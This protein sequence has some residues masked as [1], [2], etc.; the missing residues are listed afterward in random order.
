MVLD[1]NREDN[2]VSAKVKGSFQDSYEIKLTLA[3]DKISAEC[4]CPLEEEWCKH[5]VAVGLHSIEKHYYEGFITEKTGQEFTFDEENPPE[6]TEPKGAYKFIVNTKPNPKF[7]GIQVLE[8]SGSGSRNGG[9][10]ATAEQAELIPDRANENKVLTNIE[11]ILRAV[12]AMQKAGNLELDDMQKRELAILQYLYQN[13]NQNKN[14]QWYNIPFSKLD[15]LMQYLSQAEE[16][17]DSETKKRL[18]FSQEP[19]KLILKVNVSLVGNVLLSLHWNRA[20]NGEFVDEFPLEELFTFAKSAKW[21]KYKSVIFPLD[22][23]L[24]KLPF[25]LTK[26]TFTDIRD[27]DGGKFVYEELPHLKKLM[28]VEVY[29]TLD[30][31]D[32]L[33]KP[34][35]NLLTLEK[36]EDGKM[37]ATLEFEYEGTVVPY[38]KLAEKTPYVTVKKPEE[39]LIYWIKRNLELEELAYKQLLQSRFAPMQTNNLIIE[40]DN[41]I[42]FFNYLLPNAGENWKVVEK[43]DVTEFK[44]ASSPLK[45]NASIDFC[46]NVDSFKIEFSG[47]AGRNKVSFSEI[48]QYFMQGKKYFYFEKKGNIEIPLTKLASINKSLSTVD[49]LKTDDASYEVKTFRAGI[50]AELA[51]HEVVLKYSKKFQTFWDKISSFNSMEEIPLP[52]GINAEFRDYQKKGFNWLWFLYSYGL[53]GILAD[54][55]G[56]GKTLQALTLLQKAKETDGHSPSLVLCPTSVVFNWEAEI[57]KFAPNLKSLNLTGS[58]RKSSFK[59][60]KEHD[61]IITSYALLRRDI[62]VLKEVKFRSVILD[63]SQ[64]IKNYESQTAQSA[65]LLNASHRLALSGTPIEN[66]L[67]ELWSAFDFL[68]PGFLYDINEFN[69]RYGVPIQ[70][71]GDRTVESR[72]KKQI[73]PFIL[74]RMKRDIAK[75]LPDKIENI[76]YCK[77]TPDQKD[78]Y[79]DVLDNARDEI[80]NMVGTEGFEKSKMSVFT[81]LTRLRQVCCHPKLYDKEGKM[82][83]IDS[84]K[85]E[86]LKE[87]LEEIISEGHKVLLF[88]QFVQMLDIVKDWFDKTGIKYE[89]LT[90]ATKDRQ[91]AV[92]NFNNDPNIPVFLISLKAGGTGLNLTGADYVIHYDPWWNPAVEDQATDRAYR[93]GQTKNV[94][95]YRLITKGSV[96]EKIM[97]LKERK[98]D[99]LDSVISTDRNVGKSIT[100]DDIKDI[101]TPDL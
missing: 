1:S 10:K 42:D 92:N 63:E 47:M 80:Y 51:E 35:I 3:D 27:A 85:F 96:E 44:M 5:A 8:R 90:G 70:D 25:N 68:M 19:L 66:R 101:L 46:K 7:V 48:M 9:A 55:M 30:N 77:M 24:S 40:D 37:K 79:L 43:E 100:F 50:V 53:N 81:I 45:I 16:V 32:L 74:R 58:E 60:I 75:D 73:Y 95:V 12:I 99:L 21:G 56:L 59:K 76:A 28:T 71:K 64:N 97:K 22:T 41:A 93:I 87:M 78:F 11:P 23:A 84:G 29:D 67:S 61:V 86:H 65:K 2:A 13:A 52:E 98:R 18:L 88:S 39:N 20:S 91:S 33:H 17:I 36:T 89:Y 69:Y 94:F 49:A 72:L 26:S 15:G 31:L 6:I 34:P 38:G 4:S 83:N 57:K 54:D 14:V 62:D 82:G